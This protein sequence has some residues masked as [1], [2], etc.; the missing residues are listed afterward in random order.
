V[1]IANDGGNPFVLDLS[2]SDG[3]EAPVLTAKHGSR[4]WDFVQVADSFEKFLQI[5]TPP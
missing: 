3:D 2:Q 1:V 5:V 4:T